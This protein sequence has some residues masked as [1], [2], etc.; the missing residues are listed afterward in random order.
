MVM[1][2][3]GF[4][5]KIKPNSVLSRYFPKALFPLLLFKKHF[6]SGTEAQFSNVLREKYDRMFHFN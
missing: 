3:I 6:Q 2:G 5:K 4:G 1:A